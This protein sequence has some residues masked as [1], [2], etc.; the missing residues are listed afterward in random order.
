MQIEQGAVAQLRRPGQVADALGMGRVDLGL[1]DLLLGGLDLGD[2]L[3]FLLPA[4]RKRGALFLQIGQGFFDLFQAVLGGRI[5]LLAQ[6]LPLDLL[7]GDF[8]LHLV[9]LRRAGIDLH[10]QFGRRLVDQ[11]HGLV[12]QLPVGDVAVATGWPRPRW[13]CP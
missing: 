9:D 1:L 5:L 6:G 3:F 11:V 8:A 10:A 2:G 7:L 13:R 12:R 4:G